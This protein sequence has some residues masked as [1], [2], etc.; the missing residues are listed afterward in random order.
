[1]YFFLS[2]FFWEQRNQVWAQY[3]L[4]IESLTFSLKTNK[5][6]ATTKP[7]SKGRLIP[8]HWVKS[9]QTWLGLS[10]MAYVGHS[11]CSC[12]VVSKTPH[13]SIY[14]M[15]MCP[16]YLIKNSHRSHIYVLKIKDGLLKKLW[17]FS[18]SDIVP[19]FPTE[20]ETHFSVS[21][22]L[23]QCFGEIHK[24]RVIRAFSTGWAS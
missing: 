24:Q 2:L 8:F 7:M 22:V 23:E 1:M 14:F 21:L 10:W 4:F 6:A 16:C 3:T 12:F 19:K 15:V 13:K 11:I 18:V 17:D 20:A 5:T 9:G